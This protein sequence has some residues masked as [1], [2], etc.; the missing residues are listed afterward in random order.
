MQFA[1]KQPRLP[2]GSLDL[3]VD[4]IAQLFSLFVPLN[5]KWLA[6]RERDLECSMLAAFHGDRCGERSQLFF[7]KLGWV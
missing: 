6:A 3:D 4:F 5:F 7:V 1:E 2:R